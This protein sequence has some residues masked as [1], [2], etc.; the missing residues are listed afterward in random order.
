[1]PAPSFSPL[2]LTSGSYDPIAARRAVEAIADQIGTT[3]RLTQAF[4]DSDRTVDLTGL[5]DMVGQLSA[6]AL[7]L[8][9]DQGRILR[10]ALIAL[11]AD[12]D[13]I[14]ESLQPP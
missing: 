12:L 7:D 10:P 8:D 11:L 6:R 1:M 13:G 5:Q 14:A 9:P 2:A 3:L 4:I